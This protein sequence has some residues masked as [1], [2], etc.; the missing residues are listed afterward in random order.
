MVGC[1][2]SGVVCVDDTT[3]PAL[4]NVVEHSDIVTGVTELRCISLY[5]GV[6]AAALLCCTFCWLSVECNRATERRS[7]PDDDRDTELKSAKSPEDNERTE[8]RFADN[9]LS[10]SSCSSYFSCSFLCFYRFTTT[11]DTVYVHVAYITLISQFTVTVVDKRL[12]W[13]KTAYH[14]AILDKPKCAI[15]HHY[16]RVLNCRENRN[17]TNKKLTSSVVL[18]INFPPILSSTM[19]IVRWMIDSMISVLVTCSHVVAA[20]S[21]NSQ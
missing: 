21:C 13:N 15:N 3:T 20:G 19:T 12:K 2:N 8:K 16:C 4:L 7:P 17:K 11:D 1:S 9:G 18:L 5:S 10:T 6:D 14:V